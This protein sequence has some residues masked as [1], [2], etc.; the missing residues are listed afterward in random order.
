MFGYPCVI[1]VG[2]AQVV[3][4]KNER[5]MERC[6]FVDKGCRFTLRFC[7]LISR[8]SRHMS[9]HAVSRHLG[10]RWVTVKNIDR[11]YLE[12]RL[13]ALNPTRLSDL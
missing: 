1:D 6:E 12:E 4:S 5:R 13:P 7:R 10:L 2:L 11:A 3:I 9:I 8:M